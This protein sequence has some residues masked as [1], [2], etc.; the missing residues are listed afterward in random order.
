MT[1]QRRHIFWF[2]LIRAI[3]VTSILVAVVIIQSSTAD[4]I[5]VV[6]FYFI[7]LLAYLLSAVYVGLYLWW[8][9]Y[10]AQAYIQIV[11]D[12]LLITALIYI[13]GG[14]LGTL[15]LL[16]IFAI[17][18]ASIV[19]SNRAA[20]ITAGLSAILF[21]L[22]V[23]GLYLGIIPYFS[24]DQYQERSLGAVLFT[25]FLAWSLFFLIAVLANHLTNG[26][27]KARESLR[28]ARKELEIKERLATAGRFSAQLA[29]EIRN[30][31]AAV[32][33]AVQVLRGELRLDEEQ[34]SLMDIVVKESQRVS[35][36][37]EQFL[38]LASP[39]RQVFSR[40]VLREVL[41]DT[42]ALLR[43]GGTLNGRYQL[44]GNFSSAEISYYGS[45]N[46][47]KQVFLNLSKNALA[48][49]PGGGVLNIDFSEDKKKA[50]RI[51][52]AD[53]GRG[54]NEEEKK[55]LFE[56]FFSRF[57]NGRGLGLAVVRSI[58]DD[59]D[60]RIEVRS[61]PRKGTEITLLLPLREAPAGAVSRMD[62]TS[63]EGSGSGNF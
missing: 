33:G 24:P 20:Y 53:T 38:D 40:F 11:V 58:V 9:E 35:Q 47:F 23:D 42:L 44:A 36:S 10:A 57:E 4:F 59:Y 27:R 16:Y 21:G 5:P 55:H 63:R 60:G 29:H 41:E 50:V 28:L 25:M 46:Q 32:S 45:L 56:P 22:L 37:I 7:V 12:L 3:V 31:L 17:V 19:L 43:A 18:A 30:P 2:I 39:G 6:P 49:M 34:R 51:R 13:S 26:L 15:Y 8:R 1:T 48:A 14:L 61:E 62:G 52:F 54:L